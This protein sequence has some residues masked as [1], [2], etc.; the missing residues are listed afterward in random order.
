M[1]QWAIALL[2]GYQR[3]VSPWLAPACRFSPTCSEYAVQA[4]ARYGLWRG[5][6]LAVGRLLRCHPW[7]PGGFDPLR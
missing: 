5:V 1:G 2:R 3:W 7:H 4:I 6:R